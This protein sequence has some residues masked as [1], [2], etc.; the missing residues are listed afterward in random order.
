MYVFLV[1]QEINALMVSWC[2]VR[3]VGQQQEPLLVKVV[4]VAFWEQHIKQLLAHLLLT[5]NAVRVNRVIQAI[6]GY[7]TAL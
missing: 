4:K 5:L 6:T 7:K 1:Y 3:L 2:L